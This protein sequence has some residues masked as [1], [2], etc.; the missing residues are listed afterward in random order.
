MHRTAQ[1]CSHMHT[2][3]YPCRAM[4]IHAHPCT[5]MHTHAHACTPRPTHEQRCT[6]MDSP[7]PALHSPAKPCTALP[8]PHTCKHMHTVAYL[9]V[10]RHAQRSTYVRTPMHRHAQI[11]THIHIRA[12]ND[13]NGDSDGVPTPETFYFTK[14][15]DWSAA[16]SAESMYTYVDGSAA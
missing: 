4:H 3:A 11:C 13:D 6:H 7:A 8:C 15:C 9:H 5:S 14:T 1:P 16:T 10:H 2:H 12:L